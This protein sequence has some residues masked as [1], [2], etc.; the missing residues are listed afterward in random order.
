MTSWLTKAVTHFGRALTAVSVPM[1]TTRSDPTSGH[2]ASRAARSASLG[3]PVRVGV[4]VG[5][6]VRYADAPRGWGQR[7]IGMREPHC[8]WMDAAYCGIPP[9]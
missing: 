4:G 8:A 6:G 9:R 5:V 7:A 3:T 1:T 2:T